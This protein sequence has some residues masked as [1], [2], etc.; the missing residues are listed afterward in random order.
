MIA[1]TTL[2]AVLGKADL[3]TLLSE[4]EKLNEHLQQII[5]EQT[6][7]WGIKVGTV[8]ISDVGIP[9]A[10]QRAMAR[11]A[12]AER[13]RRAKVISAEAEFQA[14]ARL[15]EAADVISRTRRRSS[16]ATC[17]RIARSAWTELHGRVPAPDR[18]PQAAAGAAS[19]PA[20]TE[21]CRRATARRFVRQRGTSERRSDRRS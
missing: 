7:P 10:M 12:E 14:A 6:E 4:R 2:R 3:D 18:P 13:E 16:C 21:S 11:Q 5:D 1:Q 8:E 19:V 9:P 20:A 15:A 17:R